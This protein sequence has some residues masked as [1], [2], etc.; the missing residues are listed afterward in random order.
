MYPKV[1]STPVVAAEAPNLVAKPIKK[2]FE[3]VMTEVR[4]SSFIKKTMSSSLIECSLIE[5]HVKQLL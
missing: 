5:N 4:R 1:Q 3:K 2:V